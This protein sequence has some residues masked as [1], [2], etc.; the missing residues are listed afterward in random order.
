MSGVSA[1]D[2]FTIS[3]VFS[4]VWT[5]RVHPDPKLF[6]ADVVK[7]VIKASTLPRWFIIAVS[8]FP[9]GLLLF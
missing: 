7:A 5:N 8:S 6:V 9:F 3:N 1:F 2:V 4:G